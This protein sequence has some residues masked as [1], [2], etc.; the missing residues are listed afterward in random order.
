VGGR[1]PEDGKKLASEDEG[2][3]EA[4]KYEIEWSGVEE[5]LKGLLY[6]SNLLDAYSEGQHVCM[7]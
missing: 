1:F 7:K 4:G 2:A 6:S 3:D 5:S